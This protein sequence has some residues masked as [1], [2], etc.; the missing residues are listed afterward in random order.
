MP[1]TVKHLTIHRL[2]GWPR[3]L[4]LKTD[5][6]AMS[7]FTKYTVAKPPCKAPRNCV[8]KLVSGN[9]GYSTKAMRM[10]TK[11]P[12]KCPTCNGPDGMAKKDLARSPNRAFTMVYSSS[13]NNE[14]SASAYGCCSNNRMKAS[15]S[16]R[17]IRLALSFSRSSSSSYGVAMRRFLF[18]LPRLRSARSAS[19][20]FFKDSSDMVGTG[21]AL[22]MPGSSSSIPFGAIGPSFDWIGCAIG[23]G[24]AAFGFGASSSSSVCGASSCFFTGG[25]STLSK[26]TILISSSS[27]RSFFG[28]LRLLL[29]FFLACNETRLSTDVCCC[30][31]SDGPNG[32]PPTLTAARWCKDWM[33]TG[34]KAAAVSSEAP[35][36]AIAAIAAMSMMDVLCFVMMLIAASSSAPSQSID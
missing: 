1:P 8:G 9:P 5:T 14:S 16:L 32:L 23:S 35:T 17:S 29:C 34:E 22:W 19:I 24:V 6:T 11:A 7:A 28:L 3:S 12:M 27:L 21:M 2:T 18:F 15:V 36:N 31:G 4:A 20:C 26:S 25:G 13:S 10:M 33:L 30:V